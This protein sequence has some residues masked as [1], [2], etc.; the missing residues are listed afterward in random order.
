MTI[1]MPTFITNEINK[2]MRRAH[3]FEALF[4]YLPNHI[5]E[6]FTCADLRKI[7]PDFDSHVAGYWLARLGRFGLRV[8]VNYDEGIVKPEKP[9]KIY[10]YYNGKTIAITEYRVNSYT[11]LGFRAGY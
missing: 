7:Y 5:G 3:T 11:M 2:A 1:E 8:R 4:D 9:I 10:D 6:T